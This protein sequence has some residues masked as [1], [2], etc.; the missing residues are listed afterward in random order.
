MHRIIDFLKHVAC[1]DGIFNNDTVS[2]QYFSMAVG[3][4]L[5]KI[6]ADFFGKILAHFWSV[7]LILSVVC[8]FLLSSTTVLYEDSDSERE[9]FQK[10]RCKKFE[11]SPGLARGDENS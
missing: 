7:L 1:R 8:D 9:S 3:A 11:L 10:I 2:K 6:W 4:M 5:V